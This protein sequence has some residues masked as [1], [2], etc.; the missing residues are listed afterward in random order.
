MNVIREL[1][2]FS[3]GRGCAFAMLGIMCFVIGLSW[4]PILAARTGGVLVTVMTLVLIYRARR[5]HLEDY[6]RT[7]VWLLLAEADRPHP[8]AAQYALST[9]RREAF[10][11]FAYYTSGAAALFWLAAVLLWL[12]GFTS[13]N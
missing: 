11:Q 9:A 8:Q 1:A 2:W 5:A 13:V 3:I 10:E 6:R 7:E 4:H 12:S